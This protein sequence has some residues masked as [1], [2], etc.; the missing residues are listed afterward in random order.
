MKAYMKQYHAIFAGEHSGH[1]Y[2]R[3]FFNSET[4]VGTALMVLSLLSQDGRKFSEIVKQLDVYPSSGEIN[5]T[6][7]DMP[8]VMETIKREYTDA[9]TVD[10]LDGLSV[11]Y[12]NYWFNLRTSK[13][14][15]LIRLNVEA[16]SKRL[17]K[18]KT[19]KLIARIQ[20]LG[21]TIK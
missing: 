16:D 3:D 18:E 17:L 2:H 13:T 14:E 1:Y 8:N 5:F 4:G 10:E 12:D 19:D 21:G 20:S 15:P 6:V 7:T 9:K 11:W